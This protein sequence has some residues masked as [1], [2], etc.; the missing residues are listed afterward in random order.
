M[1]RPW[2][3]GAGSPVR[4]AEI[5]PLPEK[6]EVVLRA[7]RRCVLCCNPLLCSL[8]NEQKDHRDKL[9]L[10][11][12]ILHCSACSFK[13]WFQFVYFN[14]IQSYNYIQITAFVDFQER[15]LLS[16]YH[17]GK[18]ALVPTAKLSGVKCYARD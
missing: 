13:K 1:S 8:K 16:L 17:D 6:K 14:Q 2:L 15:L 7:K 3:T 10:L 4:A 9:S 12:L 18:S 11:P 5:A